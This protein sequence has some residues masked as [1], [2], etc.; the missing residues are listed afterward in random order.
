MPNAVDEIIAGEQCLSRL[1]YEKAYR[2]FVKAVKLNPKEGRAYFGKAEASIGMP[3]VKPEDIAALYKKAIELEPDNP[4]FIEAYAV[5][6]MDA[7]RF[8]EAE[9]LY[10][11]VAKLDKDNAPYYYSDF[12]IKFYTIAPQVMENLMDEKGK[13]IVARKSLD[14]LLKA[15]Q[16][17]KEYAKRLLD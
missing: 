17:N 3:K 5:F 8:N 14:Y 1:D 15:L 10:N 2:H 4:Q 9:S 11:M 6:C 7:G 13:E 12:A 16:I